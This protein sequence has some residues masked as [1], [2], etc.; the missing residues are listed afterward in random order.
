[1]LVAIDETR[2]LNNGQPSLWASLFDQLDLKPG[3]RVIHVGAGAGYYS[4]I[5][6]EI[7]GSTGRVRALEIDPGLA[8]RARANLEAWPQAGVVA[9]DGFAYRAQEPAD[10]IVVNVGVT[11][12]SPAWLDS[13]AE[14]GRLLVPFTSANWWGA[15][16]LV[17]RQGARYPT[18]FASR[19]GI[20]PCA[21]GRNPEAESRLTAAVAAA[22]FTAIRSLRRPPEE[23][24]DT[25]WLAGDGWWLSTAPA[26]DGPK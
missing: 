9:A 2:G 19:T 4:A 22:D 23:P 11:H 12:L 26:E 10:A 13:L 25:C 21:G 18:R 17:T 15:F 7:V 16:L 3:E 6:A 24:N 20:I 1:M 5:L 14:K 8:E